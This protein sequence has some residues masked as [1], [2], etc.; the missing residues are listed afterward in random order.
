M[1][2]QQRSDIP[3]AKLLEFAQQALMN[4]VSA[5]EVDQGIR[6][7]SGG[8]FENLAALQQGAQPPSARDWAR[9]VLQG[10]SFGLGDEAVGVMGALTPGRGSYTEERDASRAWVN[11]ARERAGTGKGLLAE[12]AGAALTGGMGIARRT[13]AEIMARTGSR[14]LAGT[15]AGAATGGASGALYGIGEG[16]ES[17]ERIARG[18]IGGTLGTIGGAVFGGLGAGAGRFTGVG[19]RGQEIAQ[20]NLTS[21]LRQAGVPPTAPGIQSALDR[22]GAGSVP[23]DLGDNLGRMARSAVNDASD[24]AA[25]GGPV[26]NI[27]Q[28]QAERG[29]R[30]ADELG[31]RAGLTKTYEESLAAAESHLKAT[32]EGFYKPLEAAF[33]RVEGPAIQEVLRDPDILP[34][35]RRV[36]REAAP[37]TWDGVALPAER[38][39]S[40]TELQ[41]VLMHLRDRVTSTKASG[42]PNASRR[43]QEV[44][45]R[46]VEALNTDVPGFQQAQ[47]AYHLASKRVEAHELGRR[48][49]NR[50]PNQIRRELAMLPADEDVQNA[51]RRGMLDRF[52]EGLYGRPAG[53]SRANELINSPR[54][55]RERLQILINDDPQLE[56]MLQA[57]QGREFRWARTMEALRGNSTTAQQLSDGNI[58]ATVPTSKQ[59]ALRSI[60]EWVVGNEQ[61]RRAAQAIIGRVLLSQGEDAAR[62]L[63]RTITLRNSLSGTIGGGGAAGLVPAVDRGLFD[64]Q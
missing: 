12:G 13:G 21:G 48:A 62:E 4:G 20:Q 35:I 18:V 63:A 46:F 11:D 9:L 37:R 28:R 14:L 8:R 59:G 60:M 10:A 53:G 15:G 36:A 40:F 41:D 51:F 19:T 17:H 6:T 58:F 34:V 64:G 22:L 33:A 39:P 23:A 31:Q 38:P 55:V 47:R 54:H 42:R 49:A 24:L 45:D 2:T 57:L 61:D 32:R 3:P 26:Q 16:E 30:I 7:A 43:A 29:P 52:E 25:P 50:P 27:Y 56:A 1:S 44:L 5:A